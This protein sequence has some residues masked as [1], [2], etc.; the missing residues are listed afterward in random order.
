[1]DDF[2]ATLLNDLL[3]HFDEPGL[4]QFCQQLGELD[5]DHLAGTEP[6]PKMTHLIDYLERLGRR[7][8]LVNLLS[9]LRP[10]L[11]PKYRPFLQDID[12]LGAQ[13]AAI[14]D[15][16]SWLDNLAAGEGAALDEPPTTAWPTQPNRSPRAQ[17]ESK[18]SWLGRL[19]QG[20]GA[21]V[22]EVPTMTWSDAERPFS[23][24]EPYQVG[25]CITDPAYFFGRELERQWLRARLL[26]MGSSV[27]VGLP[28]SGKSSLL[29]ALAYHEPLL[30]GQHFLLAHVD[31]KNGRF[32]QNSQ[33]DLLNVVWQQWLAQ[34]NVQPHR[35][36]AAPIKQVSDFDRWV[37]ILR[38]KGYRPV[39]CLDGLAPA[40]GQE[41]V[42][43]EALLAR[44]YTLGN[45]GQMAFV[46][47]A[48][49]PL[50]SLWPANWLQTGFDTIFYQLE[51]GLL[52]EQAALALL[53][54]PA[55]QRGVVIPPPLV[56]R[57]LDYCGAHPIFL[58]MGGSL[59]WQALADKGHIGS[60][61]EA[62]LQYKFRQ[63]ADSY[64]QGIW[65][66]LSVESKQ[67]FPRQTTTPATPAARVICRF[68]TGRGLL[69][70]DGT[71]YRPFSRAFEQWLA[72]TH[73]LPAAQ[74]PPNSAPTPKEAK[75]W[76][77]RLWGQED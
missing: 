23:Q 5:Y 21:P 22:D 3:D 53:T 74:T 34:I 71:T 54:E 61:D 46:L 33:L 12:R 11:A 72:Q 9:S 49:R 19:A 58:Q 13:E 73:P 7:Q 65:Q 66:T 38:Q 52:T 27:I 48:E 6:R 39:L 17:P 77:S 18:L 51:I 31:M 15:A 60:G 67:A 36:P 62:A 64:W 68:L 8:R 69:M 14:D 24:S 35:Q 43:D 63:W 37:H 41:A 10:Q 1:M 28:Y 16:L 50:S 4:R 29:Y 44:W 32:A 76:R 30:T 2:N 40:A 55:R 59:L 47:T 45:E 42:V 56:V 57:W 26:E 75:G 70:I 20:G 25:G